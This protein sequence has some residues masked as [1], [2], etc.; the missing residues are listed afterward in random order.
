MS[1]TWTEWL[2]HSSN[3][4]VYF[5]VNTLASPNPVKRFYAQDWIEEALPIYNGTALAHLSDIGPW[6]I[7][8]KPSQLINLGASLDREPFHDNSWGWAYHSQLAWR[9]QI[10]HWQKHQLVLIN[11]EKRVF[12][13]FD[14]RVA[15]TLIPHL[16]RADWALLMMPIEDCFIECGETN[17]TF[18]RPKYGEPFISPADYRLSEHLMKVWRNSEQSF[19]NIVDNF[20]FQFWEKQTAWA[21]QLDEQEGYL[22]TLIHEWMEENQKNNRDI[23]FLDDE[24]FINY[25]KT[26][27]NVQPNIEIIND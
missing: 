22:K 24:I 23:T 13:F 10:T 21:V 8:T 27:P 18:S 16:E 7:K 4:N 6:L 11:K 1:L 14:S 12:R 25:L 2:T 9:E 3:H 17:A 20:Y 15:R 26:H 5:L 19:S